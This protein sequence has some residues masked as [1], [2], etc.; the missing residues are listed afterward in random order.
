MSVASAKSTNS[1]FNFAIQNV[2]QRPNNNPFNDIASYSSN[3]LGQI[4][5]LIN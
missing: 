3:G 1:R 4:L 2:N 5:G